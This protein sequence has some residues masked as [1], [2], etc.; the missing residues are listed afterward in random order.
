MTDSK[1]VSIAISVKEKEAISTI[2]SAV[3]TTGEA[4][5]VQIALRGT[6]QGVA[7]A[8]LNLKDK[9]SDVS[10]LLSLRRT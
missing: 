6:A 3:L 8:L 1:D 7:S 2:M 10:A 5:S 9:A 4:H